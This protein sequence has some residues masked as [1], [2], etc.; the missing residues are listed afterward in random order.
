[1]D[2]GT[3]RK[4]GGGKKQLDPVM[5]NHLFNWIIKECK[6]NKVKIPRRDIINK[7]KMFSTKK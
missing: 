2:L 4:L 3:K 1:M 7:A 6:L 5:E